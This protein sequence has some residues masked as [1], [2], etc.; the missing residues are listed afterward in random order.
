[1]EKT[2]LPDCEELF[3]N[4]VEIGLDQVKRNELF[5]NIFDERSRPDADC[6]FQFCVLSILSIASERFGFSWLSLE[7]VVSIIEDVLH[8]VEWL[9]KGKKLEL[10]VVEYLNNYLKMAVSNKNGV[11]FSFSRVI[12]L[13]KEL[14]QIKKFEKIYKK[15]MENLTLRLP[16]PSFKDEV[17]KILRKRIT[18]LSS[19]QQKRDH[20]LKFHATKGFGRKRDDIYSMILD[21]LDQAKCSVKFMIAYYSEDLKAL[22]RIL[23]LK[24]YEGTQVQIILRWAEDSKED[25]KKLIE[26]IFRTINLK[27]SGWENFKY[28]L[29]PIFKKSQEIEYPVANLHAKMLIVDRNKLLI[30]SANVTVPSLRKNIEVAISTTHNA[31]VNEAERF[32]D[33]IWDSLKT[34]PELGLT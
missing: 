24:A 29:Y 1:M 25:N 14:F 27:Q 18:D 28:A 22:A 16:Y 3:T 12:R 13:K 34:N 19:L 7:E 21:M 17:I 15:C 26:E 11:Q 23:G 5:N 31:T 8:D 33:E 10:I 9:P 30:S 32:F 6:Q 2:V 4:A 20:P